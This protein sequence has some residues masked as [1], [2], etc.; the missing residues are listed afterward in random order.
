MKRAKRVPKALRTESSRAYT[1]SAAAMV[2]AV[3]ARYARA[4]DGA[5]LRCTPAQKERDGRRSYQGS[6]G[7][8][9]F[10]SA[11]QAGR[12]AAELRLVI[13]AADNVYP[14]PRSRHGHHHLTTPDD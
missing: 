3:V 1:R 2:N 10:D 9:I 12:C 14:C 7:K 6:A 4:R 13:G 5:V 8:V 11:D